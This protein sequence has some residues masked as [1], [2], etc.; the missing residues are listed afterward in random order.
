[1]RVAT[2]Q[3]QLLS[4]SFEQVLI[5]TFTQEAS[6][7]VIVTPPNFKLTLQCGSQ[8]HTPKRV[9]PCPQPPSTPW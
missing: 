8:W 7:T 6:I 1:M 4:S 2:T 9:E 5:L 3:E